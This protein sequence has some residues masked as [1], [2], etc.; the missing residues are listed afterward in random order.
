MAEP[1][2]LDAFIEAAGAGLSSAQAQIAGDE[3]ATVAMAVSAARLE[4]RVLLDVASSGAVQIVSV[5]RDEIQSLG[6]GADALSTITVDFVALS[7]SDDEPG[8]PTPPVKKDA[9]IDALATRDDVNRLSEVLGPL[10]FDATFVPTRAAWLVT[11]TD[12][13]GRRVREIIVDKE[14]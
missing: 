10:T 13:R 7:T 12:E 6:A 2:G 14:S 8:A 3:L 11:A 9:A 5:G 1:T 4:A